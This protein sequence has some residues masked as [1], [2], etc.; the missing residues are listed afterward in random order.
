M[1]T[2]EGKAK[3][4]NGN[5]NGAGERQSLGRNAISESPELAEEVLSLT[6]DI[7]SL[8]RRLMTTKNS[9]LKSAVEAERARIKEDA[10]RIVNRSPGLCTAFADLIGKSKTLVLGSMSRFTQAMQ[11]QA[12]WIVPLTLFFKD[13]TLLEG[14]AM[15][16]GY[17]IHKLPSP[18]DE[19]KEGL[20]FRMGK[21]VG[22]SGV[23][24]QKMSDALEDGKI[25]DAE[26]RELYAEGCVIIRHLLEV[27]E[28]V[29][30]IAE[31][32]EAARV[33]KGEE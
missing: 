25:T 33:Q 9:E 29:K 1:K 22:E 23:L 2:G 19:T 12:S 17:G 6:G 16:C 18:S 15:R 28:S 27:L 11:M 13:T 7:Q 3:G 4:S 10:E 14:I 20:M 32:T 30:L 26:K 31:K 5:G 24:L 8:M 21:Y